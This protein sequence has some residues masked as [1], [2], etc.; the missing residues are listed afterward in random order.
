MLLPLEAEAEGDNERHGH[1][2]RPSDPSHRHELRP[3]R[4]EVAIGGHGDRSDVIGS[5]R[6]EVRLTKSERLLL[7]GPLAIVLSIWLIVPALLGLAATL[8]N[9]AL[10]QPAIRWVGLHN[11]EMLLAD[12]SFAAAV[13]NIAVFSVLAVPTELVIGFGLAY[14]LRRPLRGRALIRLLLLLPWLI[15]PVASGVMWHFLLG[16]E[17][18]FLNFAARSLGMPSLPS[19][20]SQHGLDLLTV[21]LVESWRVAPLV[22]FLFLPGLTAIPRERWEDALLDGLPTLHKIRHVAVP[23]MAPLIL[24]VTMLLIGGAL[25]TFDSVLTMTG[26]GPGTETVTPALYSHDMAFTAGNWP[27]GA[28]SGWLIGGAVLLAGLIYLRLASRSVK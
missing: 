28:A 22:A 24:A 17:T 8:T 26:G 10:A 12:R 4:C 15:S 25:A 14:L 9:Y 7:Y 11:F 6:R 23:A 19:P 18:G 5:A 13:R 16:S 1:A 20:L 2:L 21:V 3:H 27:A